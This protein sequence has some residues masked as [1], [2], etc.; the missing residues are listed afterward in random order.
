[1]Y[2]APSGSGVEYRTHSPPRTRI[3]WPAR[4]LSSPSSC[5]T[6][7]APLSTTVYSSKSGRWPGSTQPEGERMWAT[8][9]RSSPLLTR[10]TYSSISFGL[11]PAASTRDGDWISSGIASGIPLGAILRPE[12]IELHGQPVTYLQSGEGPPLVLIHGIT[13]RASCWE[14]VIP[15]L[16]RD[17]TVIAPDLLGH[18]G[19]AKPRGDYSLGSHA[20]GIR[21]LLLALGHPKVTVVGH[22]LGGG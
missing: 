8:L 3:A 2:S 1:M 6:C 20:S 17:H 7:R 22:S 18:G 9:T 16:A 19:S 12:T 5:S 4:T 10:P 11:V 21:D 14:Q 15:G 13:S